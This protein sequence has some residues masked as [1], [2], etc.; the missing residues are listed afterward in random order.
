[1]WP[2]CS[3][4]TRTS[5]FPFHPFKDDLQ[6]AWRI[7]ATRAFVPVDGQSRDLWV[8][9]A[10]VLIAIQFQ[11]SNFLSPSPLTRNRDLISACDYAFVMRCH[12]K[13]ISIFVAQMTYSFN[14][15]YPRT[16]LVHFCSVPQW[17]EPSSSVLE[18][19][20][21][22][23]QYTSILETNLV[24]RII[25]LS[26]PW[27]GDSRIAC[28][29]NAMSVTVWQDNSSHALSCFELHTNFMYSLYCEHPC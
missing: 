19:V 16:P 27:S 26:F 7:S 25:S 21:S 22:N 29:C 15:R 20:H 3:C 4:C 9:R 17:V 1:M 28:L 11:Y 10:R 6:R 23:Q 24:K 8:K 12:R 18:K 13:L 14:G 2:C 5:A